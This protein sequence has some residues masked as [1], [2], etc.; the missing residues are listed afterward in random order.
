[1]IGRLQNELVALNA[2]HTKC[3]QQLAATKRELV[4]AQ[5]QVCSHCRASVFPLSC[6]NPGW[7]GMILTQ[8]LPYACPG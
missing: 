3:E 7:R 2:Q 6:S 4:V 1:M 8:A 5:Q